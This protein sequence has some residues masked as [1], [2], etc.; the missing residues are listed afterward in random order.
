MKKFLLLLIPLLSNYA[1]IAQF[2]PQL[3]NFNKTTTTNDATH[4]GYE[5]CA[6]MKVYEEKIKNDPKAE[7]LEQFEAWLQDKIREQGGLT[8]NKQRSVITIPYIIHVIHN[9]EAVGTATN[10]PSAWIT[11]QMAAMNRDFRKA[12]SDIANLPAAFQSL[13][14]DFEIEFCPAVVDPQGNILAEPGVDRVNRNTKGW[15]APPYTSTYFDNNVKPNTIWNPDNYLNIWTANLSGGVLGY[16]TFP[17]TT[18]L[19]GLTSSIGTATTD[20]VVILHTAFGDLNS[21]LTANYNRGRTLVHEVGHWL[22][23]RHIWGD[24]SCGNDFC[25]DTPTQQTSNS[26][27]PTFPKV[28]C[29]N[30]PNGDMFY[31]YMDYS[32]DAC[33]YCF[34]NDQKTRADIVMANSPRR[35]SLLSSTVCALPGTNVGIASISP[36]CTSGNNQ[37]VQIT[38]RNKG[39]SVINPGEVALNLTLSGGVSGTYSALNTTSI[40]TNGTEIISIANVTV[41]TSANVTYQASATLANDTYTSDNTATTTFALGTPTITTSTNS[42]CSG[43]SFTLTLSN[44]H[45]TAGIQWQSSTNG[46]TFTNISGATS[47]TLNR[48]QTAATFYRCQSTCASMPVV[49]NVI[50]VTIN[51]PTNCYCSTTYTNGCNSGDAITRVVLG[52]LNNTSTCGTGFYTF[53]SAAAVPTI[54]KGTGSSVSVT[55]G[56]DNTNFC[57]IWIDANN[58]G[59]FAT[60][61]YYANNTASVGSN[62]TF[63]GNI[64]IPTSITFTGNTRMRIRGGNDAVVTSSQACGTSSSTYGETEDYIVNI[65]NACTVPTLNTPS[66][67]STTSASISTTCSG[68]SGTYI[69]EY[70][71][72]NFVPGTGNSAGT[73]GTIISGTST[74]F[75]LS[76]LIAGAS[77]DVYIRQS[78]GTSFSANSSKRTFTTLCP[79]YTLPYTE[80]FNTSLLSPCLGTTTL[81]SGAVAPLLSVVA[82]GTNP[83]A[84]RPEG[85]NMLNFNAATATAGAQLRLSSGTISTVGTSVVEVSFQMLENNGA[86]SANDKVIL[87]YSIDEGNTWENVGEN[88]RYN[89]SVTTAW[90][91]RFFTLP[92]NAGNINSLKI[93]LLFTSAQGNN[94]FIDDLRVFAVDPIVNTN[95]NTCQSIVLNNVSGFNTYRVKNGQNS[96]AEIKPNGVN[97]GTLTVNVMENLAGTSNIP[98][99]NNGV[100]YIPRY[101]SISSSA[102]NPLPQNVDI[103][104]YVPYEELNDFNIGTNK[105]ESIG[106]LTVWEYDNPSNPTTENCITS[107]N[108][109]AHSLIQNSIAT[110]LGTGFAINFSTNRLAEFGIFPES[111][112]TP[113]LTILNAK[114]FLTSLDTLTGLMNNYFAS[115]ASFP[116][117]DPYSLSPFNSNFIHVNNSTIASTTPIALSNTGGNAIIDWIF[118]ELRTGLSNATSVIYTK[119]ALLQA[120]GDIVDMDG[121]S[122]LSLANVPA[123]NYYVALRHRYHLGIRTAQAVPLNH[124]SPLLNFTNNSLTL[125]GTNSVFKVSTN[126][127]TLRSGD[128]NAD[129]SIDALDTILWENQNGLFDDFS[130]TADYNMDGSVDAFDSVLWELNNGQFQELD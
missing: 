57:G 79:T 46:T 74:S 96:Y 73:G 120:D 47:A 84:T 76:G 20:G 37:T 34:T 26:G 9:G 69:L 91:T 117:T 75:N 59:T 81:T 35:L 110:D 23:L 128:A 16:A 123:G 18:L 70:G 22:G 60:T 62:G 90:Y 78:C 3:N 2:L 44:P 30:G 92:A 8:S 94:I 130:L 50:Q 27:C 51:A 49:S 72:Q 97:L 100:P 66:N 89:P 63:V 85:T 67:I 127:Y 61:E 64:T 68:C 107:D 21:G 54:T 82:S 125:N 42:V 48:T 17:S 25:N 77:Y 83:T 114:V 41:N 12:N 101:F 93:G 6:T 129:G 105:S 103:K 111:G 104:I 29:S 10:I 65:I 15:N 121:I 112:I 71:A 40:A 86:A 4:D 45:P 88:Q 122:P 109:Y 31:N 102:A 124:L 11:A 5:R 80:G 98:T 55:F 36:P 14:A 38:I 115:L 32:Y 52:N 1:S 58:D 113:P 99:L 116:M 106:T 7:T 95:A 13:A 56:S 19:Q 39:N 53:F 119:S 43:A 87:Q 118:I 126:Q 28:T 24:S 108:T 33:L